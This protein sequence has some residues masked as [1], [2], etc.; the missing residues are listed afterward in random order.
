MMFGGLL[1]KRKSA[2]RDIATVGLFLLFVVNVLEMSGIVFFRINVE[3]MMHFDKF[4][5]LFNS[6]ILF[7]TFIYFILSAR[8]IERAGNYYSEYFAL[9]F[10]F[11]A[12]LSLLLLSVRS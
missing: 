5:L 7:S 3:G 2:V 4:S 1:L 8:D 9:R 12:V 10:L 6:I 11:C